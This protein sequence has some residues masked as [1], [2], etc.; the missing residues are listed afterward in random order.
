MFERFDE[1]ALMVVGT[2]QVEARA[3]RHRA[4]GGEHLLLG[5]AKSDP[6]LLEVGAGD[7]REQV[8]GLFGT[9]Q[10][11][12][13]G[14][15]PF[16]NT[17][18]KALE[19]AVDEAGS[20]GQ[21]AVRPAHVLLALL[22][23]DEHARTVVQALGHRLVDVRE[24]ANAASH[25]PVSRAPADLHQA[26]REGFAVAVTLGDDLPLGDLGNPRTDARVLLAM[27]LADG[28]A[29]RLLRDHGVDEDAV[30]RLAPDR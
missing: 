12:S 8:I 19:L 27:L 22:R 7:V 9:G 16:T 24:R 20:H 17:A 29:A 28:R 10:T 26:L 13:A 1:S 18:T 5:V 21:D 4:I 6:I 25:R 2:A 11:P 3:L 15:M 23:V 14:Q 30:R